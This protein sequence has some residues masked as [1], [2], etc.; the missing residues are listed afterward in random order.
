MKRKALIILI[1]LVVLGFPLFLPMPTPV[2]AESPVYVVTGRWDFGN[3]TGWT[4]DAYC[5]DSVGSSQLHLDDVETGHAYGYTT[6]T[7]AIANVSKIV[8]KIDSLYSTAHGEL[9]MYCSNGTT[10]TIG[11]WSSTGVK[12]LT[13]TEGQ[14]FNIT[15]IGV[16]WDNK[17]ANGYTVIDYDYV[18]IY[19]TF[20][21]KDWRLAQGVGFSFWTIP[22]PL[23]NLVQTIAFVFW[24][25]EFMG[26]IY[27]GVSLLGLVMMPISSVLLVKRIK[28]HNN[29]EGFLV[30]MF[31]FLLGC[32]LFVGG[33]I[34]L[35]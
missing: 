34:S 11:G 35:L 29:F 15:K 24:G 22:A 33:V 4:N 12:T 19:S 1:L 28:E 14:Y 8:V 17:D 6:F 26:S 9:Q 18:I 32:A 10:K 20:W 13:F 31:L 27:F 21:I 30:A 25:E 7:K 16:G 3:L 5:Y 23:W 2:K